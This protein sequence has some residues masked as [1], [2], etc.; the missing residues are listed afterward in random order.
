MIVQNQEVY[1]RM[2]FTYSASVYRNT[3][4]TGAVS[5]RSS[6]LI[7]RIPSISFIS[8]LC[9][10]GVRVPATNQQNFAKFMRSVSVL[11]WFV[12]KEVSILLSDIYHLI[13]LIPRSGEVHMGEAPVVLLIHFGF[14]AHH[15]IVDN[16]SLSETILNSVNGP[17]FGFRAC[18]IL[19]FAIKI[20]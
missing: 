16:S 11:H 7:R 13:F 2:Y 18:A 9:D 3:T 20:L 12:E 8:T 4:V 14:I 10:P 19:W 6:K 1:D 5:E 15:C 17:G